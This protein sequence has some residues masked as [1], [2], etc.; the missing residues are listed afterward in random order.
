MKN[1]KCKI[2]KVPILHFSFYM[3]PVE[4]YIQ[5]GTEGFIFA[6]TCFFSYLNQERFFT[7]KG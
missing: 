4:L 3:K 5:I 7:Y 1:V 2:G 6:M